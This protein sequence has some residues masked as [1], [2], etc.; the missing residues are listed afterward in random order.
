MSHSEQ[1][2]FGYPLRTKAQCA[3]C[4]KDKS[5]DL[6]GICKLCYAF[7]KNGQRVQ[8]KCTMDKDDWSCGCQERSWAS[9]PC[10]LHK[11]SN[12]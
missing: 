8:V 6:T 3:N 2:P 10:E 4:A 11:Y 7:Y 5:M 12:N 9:Y 1:T